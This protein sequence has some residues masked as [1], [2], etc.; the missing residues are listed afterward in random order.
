MKRIISLVLLGGFLLS[1]LPAQGGFKDLKVLDF[2][3][4]KELKA[5]MKGMSKDL[6][7]KCKFCHDMDD[8]SADTKH[9]KIARSMMKMTKN[10]N[11]NQFSWAEEMKV[12][13]WTCH[14]GEKEPQVYRKDK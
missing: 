4:E 2:K 7:V 12:S 8:K 5:Y 14:R 9:K 10:L 3:T 6:G 13:C 11:E 1:T